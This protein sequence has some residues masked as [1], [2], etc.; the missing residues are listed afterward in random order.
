[1]ATTAQFGKDPS[2]PIA[3]TTPYDPVTQKLLYPEDAGKQAIVT[4]TEIIQAIKSVGSKGAEDVTRVRVFLAVSNS[5]TFTSLTGNT[6]QKMDDICCV[7]AAFRWRF[8]GSY[9]AAGMDQL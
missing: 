8:A 2:S 4:L 6:A 5:N 7:Q 9:T 3:G 1:M